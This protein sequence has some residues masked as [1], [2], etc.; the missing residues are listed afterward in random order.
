[1]PGECYKRSL[2]RLNY[3]PVG[4][5]KTIHEVIRDLDEKI[6]A[7]RGSSCRGSITF[8]FNG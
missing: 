5:R 3:V 4:F 7:F 2:A 1:M 6:R 8:K